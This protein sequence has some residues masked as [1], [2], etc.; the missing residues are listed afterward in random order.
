MTTPTSNYMSPPSTSGA[1]IESSIQFNMEEYQMFPLVLDI[2]SR[3]KDDEIDLIR[4]INLTNDRK[5]KAIN[6]FK[7][8]P[9]INRSLEEQEKLLKQHKQTLQKKVNLLPSNFSY[10]LLFYTSELLEKLKKL[11]LFQKYKVETNQDSEMKDN[12]TENNT[13]N[14]TE[15]NKNNNEQKIEE[16]EEETLQQD[17]DNKQDTKEDEDVEN[18]EDEE[19]EEDEDIMKE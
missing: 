2:I 4:A 12:N 9:G 16:T 14:I 5:Q 13:E 18:K 6:N 19:D 11:E 8:L 15:V 3:I 7:K 1:Q 10:T 17:D